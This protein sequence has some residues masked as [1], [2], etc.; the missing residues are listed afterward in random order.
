MQTI[1]FDPARLAPDV[2]AVLQGMAAA[3]VPAL[4]TLPI[5]LMR[6]AYAQ[7]GAL[8]GGTPLPMADVRD[9][10]AQGPAGAIPLRLYRPESASTG[11]AIVYAHGGGWTAG[12]LDT[13]DKICRRL[14]QAAGCAVVAIGYRLAPEHPAPAGPQDVVA[15]ITW[16]A[17]NADGLAIDPAR[18]AVAGDSAGG[19][20]A[21]VAC[22]QLRGSAVTLR[23]QV[24]FYPSTD[25]SPA[26]R[27]FP[28]RHENAAMP[29]LTLATMQAMVAPFVEGFD[30]SDPRVSP[31]RAADLRGLPPALIYTAACDVLRDDGRFYAE[32]LRAAEVPVDYVELPGMVHGFVEMAGVLPA[33]VHALEHAAAFLRERLARP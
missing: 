4:E 19:S 5:P 14:A 11:P 29:P 6:Q 7:I 2:L 30:P 15:A 21:A 22:Q 27:E 24:L 28:A 32:S 16:L 8:L 13:H 3:G 23:A 17:A 18:L 9:L 26:A 33:A 25:L 31:L 10:H 1:P 20:L 12:D